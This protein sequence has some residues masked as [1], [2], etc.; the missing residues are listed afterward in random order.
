MRREKWELEEE[1]M[2]ALRDENDDVFNFR[3]HVRMLYRTIDKKARVLLNP[4]VR[5]VAATVLVLAGITFAYIY[6]SELHPP[7]EVIYDRFYETFTLPVATRG[8]LQPT[9][10][11]RALMLYSSKNYTDAL[12]VTSSFV[13]SSP[14][15]AFFIS[16]LCYQQMGLMDL[17]IKNY[18]RGESAAI[19]YKEHIQWYK[20][21]AFIKK[22]E[23]DVA[24]VI[25]RKLEANST[26]YGE[27]ASELIRLIGN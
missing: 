14:E 24:T 3:Q 16:G 23:M 27:R 10:M 22:N 4:V 11:E 9:D 5:G 17:A 8:I 6:L 25:L 26:V 13:E 20:A 12:E 15:F 1:I 19:Y 21:L 7:A 2:S 18:D